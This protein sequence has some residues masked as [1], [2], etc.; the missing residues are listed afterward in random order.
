MCGGRQSQH[1]YTGYSRLNCSYFLTKNKL[2]CRVFYQCYIQWVSRR[3][4]PKRKSGQIINVNNTF[5]VRDDHSVCDLDR[6]NGK[7]L[8]H[9]GARS[10]PL[11]LIL[12]Q[13]V[14]FRKDGSEDVKGK[15]KTPTQSCFTNYFN[16]SLLFSNCCFSSMKYWAFFSFV[17]GHSSIILRCHKPKRLGT[18]ML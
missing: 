4:Q 6:M 8:P 17:T 1:R 9:T 11:P 2:N 16:F 12:N 18:I 14:S 13:W 3:E 10:Q 15:K 7:Y 5:W